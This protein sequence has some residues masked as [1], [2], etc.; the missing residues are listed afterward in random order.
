MSSLI[1]IRRGSA[2]EWSA[3]GPVLSSGEIGYEVDTGNFKVG[4]GTTGWNSLGYQLPYYTG[5]KTSFDNAT[6]SVNSANDCVGIGTV[7]PTKKLDVA[8][9]V[10][11]STTLAVT[12]DTTLTGDLAVNGGDITTT[13]TTGNLF[14]ATVTTLNLAS[15]ATAVSVG[16]ASSVITIPSTTDASSS[17]TGSIKTAGGV[18]IAKKLYV[19]TDLNVGGALAVTGKATSAATVSGDGST[20]LVTKGYAE[21]ASTKT[22]TATSTTL[23]SGQLYA[24]GTN[25]IAIQGYCFCGA[26]GKNDNYVEYKLYTDSGGTAGETSFISLCGQRDNGNDGGSAITADFNFCILIPSAYQSVRFTFTG[27]VTGFIIQN[28]M[29]R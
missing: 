5:L 9:S 3:S 10:G 6:I 25:V 4:D 17:T 14:N 8:G 19:G 15:A 7:S 12:G 1:Q 27:I 28:T 26:G 22:V 21:T 20:T 23:T 29:S 16:S 13:S 11:I 18:G 24:F 2:A